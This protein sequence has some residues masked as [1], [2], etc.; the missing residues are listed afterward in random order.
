MNRYRRTVSSAFILAVSLFYFL[1]ALFFI[2]SHRVRGV[3]DSGFVLR[4][5]GLFLVLLSGIL[6]VQSIRKD[7]RGEKNEE[8]EKKKE[9]LNVFGTAVLLL[10]YIL[11]LEPLGFL[12]S[13]VLYLL[14]QFSY[15]TQPD[16]LRSVRTLGLYLAV[17][18][19]VS[20]GVY[21]LFLKAFHLILP[22]GIL[23]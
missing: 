3:P 5:V 19:T 11:L 14:A 22:T 16:K 23:G 8:G 17:A 6:L 12:V 20:G 10:V 18:L 2:E 9:T 7:W 1:Y 15:L 13:T 4:I 21:F